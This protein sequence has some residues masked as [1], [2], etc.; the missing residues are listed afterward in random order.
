M[1]VEET[2]VETSVKRGN[3]T[4]SNLQTSKHVLVPFTVKDLNEASP[5]FSFGA[6]EV[7]MNR[8][9]FITAIVPGQH[10][11]VVWDGNV[12]TPT[13]RLDGYPVGEFQILC[14]IWGN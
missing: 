8:C 14:S 2:K 10:T 12:K 3:V 5:T 1:I 7:G 9:T 6:G 13:M 11:S 4:R